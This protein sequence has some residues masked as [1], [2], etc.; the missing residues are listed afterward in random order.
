MLSFIP[1][2]R[3]S[4][5][6]IGYFDNNGR[7]VF[8]ILSCL[9]IFTNIIFV[10]LYLIRILRGKRNKL[11]SLEKIMLGLS[12][13]ETSISICWMLSAFFYSSNE[14]I[15]PDWEDKD[16]PNYAII[17]SRGGVNLGCSIIADIQIFFYVIDWLFI[18]FSIIQVKDIILNPVEAVLNAKKK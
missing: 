12:I 4:I 18:S 17:P 13:S 3:R 15:R 1:K 8:I 6:S 16:N 5:V 2:L 11:S 10:V 9:G 7:I 14:K